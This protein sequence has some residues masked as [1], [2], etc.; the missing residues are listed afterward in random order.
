MKHKGFTVVELIIVIVVIGILAGISV[1]G[2]GTWRE[3]TA[4]TEV[5]SDLK[6]AA[7]AMNNYQNFNNN[8]PISG[9][10]EGYK[11]SP[12]VNIQRVGN[13]STYCIAGVSRSYP[14]IKYFVNSNTKN[15]APQVGDC[16]ISCEATVCDIIVKEDISTL[17]P[18]IR[19]AAVL[20]SKNPNSLSETSLST[21]PYKLRG[22][23][24]NQSAISSGSDYG[25]AFMYCASSDWTTGTAVWRNDLVVIGRS[26]SGKNF[27]KTSAGS[28]PTEFVTQINSL[29]SC[30][31]IFIPSGNPN[32]VTGTKAS[33]DRNGWR[34]FVTN[35]QE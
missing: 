11:A 14:S 27:A 4:K 34:S 13:Q 28:A 2:Y 10:P 22:Y 20:Q 1:V 16:S 18:L 21:L 29:T 8:Y 7:L 30:T 23:A 3:R 31:D 35:V 15:Q 19:Q 6:N 33:S 5:I 24:Y 12:G 9:M 25:T 26:K 17:Y 32:V